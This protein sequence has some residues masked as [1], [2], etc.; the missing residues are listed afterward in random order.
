M[1]RSSERLR[2]KS[3]LCG[4]CRCLR[5]LFPHGCLYL[6]DRPYF[7]EVPR[8]KNRANQLRHRALLAL[9]F[10]IY[11]SERSSRSSRVRRMSATS[12]SRSIWP[13]LS[14]A[15]LKPCATEILAGRS[16]RW[17]P[18]GRLPIRI[19]PAI[20]EPEAIGPV[21]R[22]ILLSIFLGNAPAISESKP[23]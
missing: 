1:K 22:P 17:N 20:G 16:Q 9:H 4:N 7:V 14:A 21:G 19:E 23:S 18:R 6:H 11:R 2:I 15:Y 3:G 12:D 5:Q 10:S 8:T 13:R